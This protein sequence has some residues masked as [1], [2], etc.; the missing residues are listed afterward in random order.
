MPPAN[1][2]GRPKPSL[3]LALRYTDQHNIGQSQFPWTLVYTNR[4]SN[5]HRPHVITQSHPGAKAYWTL[6]VHTQETVSLAWLRVTVWNRN[7]VI[8]LSVACEMLRRR[9]SNYKQGRIS[10]TCWPNASM[11]G[12]HNDDQTL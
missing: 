12:N 2:L 4:P 6:S 5:K 3:L 8:R 11:T 1:A 10:L 9:E 7:V